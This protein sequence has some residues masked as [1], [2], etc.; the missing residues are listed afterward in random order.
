MKNSKIKNTLF[1]IL[2]IIGTTLVS[3]GNNVGISEEDKVFPS[4][5]SL[6]YNDYED[7]SVYDKTKWY[8]NELKDLPLPDPFVIEEEGKYYVFG[9]T[10][11][12]GAKTFD[13]Y[14]TE[15]FSTWQIHRNIVYVKD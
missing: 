8:K 12:T 14:E 4:N 10:D 9:T 15:D 5:S 11:R 1:G 7:D 3:C 13:C 2:I 6:N